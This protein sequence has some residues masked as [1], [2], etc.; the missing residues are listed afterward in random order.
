MK[1]LLEGDFGQLEWDSVILPPKGSYLTI[2]STEYVVSKI[3]ILTNKTSQRM[4]DYAPTVAVV[5]LQI[6]IT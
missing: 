3:R 1:I 2:E 6:P 4:T 5:E